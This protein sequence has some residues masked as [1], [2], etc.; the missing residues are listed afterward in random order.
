MFFDSIQRLLL[1]TQGFDLMEMNSSRVPLCYVR[2]VPEKWTA[3]RCDVKARPL[4]CG[5]RTLTTVLQHKKGAAFICSPRLLS[6]RF[7][8]SE[9]KKKTS[10]MCVQCEHPQQWRLVVHCDFPL[11]PPPLYSSSASPDKSPTLTT[12]SRPK[13]MPSPLYLIPLSFRSDSAM[14]F[15]GHSRMICSSF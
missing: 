3:Q 5:V 2:A 9:K 11:R 10:C 14:L 6:Q 12:L 4:P 7:F 1:F 15:P 13:S 8:W